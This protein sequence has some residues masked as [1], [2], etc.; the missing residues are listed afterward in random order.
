MK[1]KPALA[2]QE[3][4]KELAVPASATGRGLQMA[5]DGKTVVVEPAR[6][7]RAHAVAALCLYGQ[8]FGFTHDDVRLLRNAAAEWAMVSPPAIA[9]LNLADRIAALLPP[10]GE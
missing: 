6:W 1:I 4:A 10:E 8:P 2:P 5:D 7:E 9:A 3:W